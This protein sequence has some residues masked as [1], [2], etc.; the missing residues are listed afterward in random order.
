MNWFLSLIRIAGASFPVSA[1]LV[2]FQA[3]VDSAVFAK[4]LD[5]LDDPISHLH[6]DVPK[7]SKSLYQQIKEADSMNLKFDDDFYTKYSRALAALES[8]GHVRGSHS[9]GKR[10]AAGLWVDDPT[11]MSYLAY[12]NED[13]KLMTQ[14]YKTIDECSPGQWLVGAEIRET[15]DVPTPVIKAMFESPLIC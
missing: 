13:Q 15:I 4:R 8:A 7:L 10:Y 9:L 2:Q 12:R 1:S 14:L 11:Y 3:E 6:D 5:A